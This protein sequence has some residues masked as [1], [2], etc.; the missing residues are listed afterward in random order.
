[1]GD[2]EAFAVLVLITAVVGLLAVLSNRFSERV[3]IPAPAVF[4]AAAAVA[5]ALFPDLHT[6]RNNSSNAW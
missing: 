2:T 5:I 1:M 3:H 6:H 4:L